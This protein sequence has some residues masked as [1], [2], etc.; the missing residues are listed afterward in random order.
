MDRAATQRATIGRE[1]ST[2]AGRI[3]IAD[4][5]PDA[6][7]ATSL[8]LQTEGHTVK[9]CSGGKALLDQFGE[10][11]PDV[12]ILDLS[13]PGVTGFDA[14]RT[15][16]DARKWRNFL[17]IALTGYTTLTDQF[18]SRMAGFDYHLAKPAGPSALLGLIRDYL[19]QG[20]GWK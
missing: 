11:R 7:I 13:M 5:N 4:D 3:L 20:R 17:L 2:L 16:R 1:P 14:A 9:G 6:V 8:L 12:V 19:Q 18:L 10:F 15:L